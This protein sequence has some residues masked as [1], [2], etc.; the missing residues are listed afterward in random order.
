[1]PST[2]T[3][4]ASTSGCRHIHPAAGRSTVVLPTRPTLPT[5]PGGSTKIRL[6]NP[7]ELLSRL[8]PASLFPLQSPL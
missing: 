7:A 2:H 8:W 4:T 5:A 6:G 3:A 1:M